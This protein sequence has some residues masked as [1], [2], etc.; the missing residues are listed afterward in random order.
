M[1][2]PTRDWYVTPKN[3]LGR[4]CIKTVVA[5][6]K[7]LIQYLRGKTDEIHKTHPVKIAGLVDENRTREVSNTQYT[8]FYVLRRNKKYHT[9]VVEEEP[10]S[11]V[12][13][14]LEIQNEMVFFTE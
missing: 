6:F 1:K 10:R 2:F 9:T 12:Y 5:H 14:V 3:E 7:I 8:N 4:I 11:K 13:F